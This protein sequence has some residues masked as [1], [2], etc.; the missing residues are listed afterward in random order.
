MHSDPHIIV[1][2][3]DELSLSDEKTG[4]DP[5]LK[6]SVG[7]QY[8]NQEN[9]LGVIVAI[10]ARNG[11]KSPLPCFM[12]AVDDDIHRVSIRE[13]QEWKHCGRINQKEWDTHSV[14]WLAAVAKKEATAS[15]S[16][17]KSRKF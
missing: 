14:V 10:T 12:I 15:N 11:Q 17:L 9:T 7:D 13:F 3:P 8:R 5:Q 4:T 6:I 2:A 16:L 1:G